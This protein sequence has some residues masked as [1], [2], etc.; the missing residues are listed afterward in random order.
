MCF[1]QVQLLL[2]VPASIEQLSNM[3]QTL[4]SLRALHAHLGGTLQQLVRGPAK[5]P[6][7][8]ALLPSTLAAL[9]HVE[10][11]HAE[12]TRA[13]IAVAAALQQVLAT[14]GTFFA[15]LFCYVWACVHAA[16]AGRPIAGRQPCNWG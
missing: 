15:G 10:M 2:H 9:E 11:L 13:C 7:L 12:H 6:R 3:Q 16:D 8:H 5:D 1:L 14:F 4:V